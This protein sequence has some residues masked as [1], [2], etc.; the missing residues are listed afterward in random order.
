MSPLLA[1][2]EDF[3]PLVSQGGCGIVLTQL[4]LILRGLFGQQLD[5]KT[6]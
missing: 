1:F 6:L 5:S 4:D 2:M 3:N